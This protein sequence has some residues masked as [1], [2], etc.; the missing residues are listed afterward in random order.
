MFTP[1]TFALCKDPRCFEMGA[2]PLRGYA[3]LALTVA[4]FYLSG[5]EGSFT[6]RYLHAAAHPGDVPP[7]NCCAR[8]A[9]V[10]VAMH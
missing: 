10:G 4:L 5:Y 9:S 7:P 3:A 6:H 1:K 8:R 2:T